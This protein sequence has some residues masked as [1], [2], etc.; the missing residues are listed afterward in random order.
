MFSRSVTRPDPAPCVDEAADARPLGTV[1]CACRFDA[2][3]GA[4]AHLIC[5][6]PPDLTDDDE[7]AALSYRVEQAGAE[8]LNNIVE[9]AYKGSPDG[10]IQAAIWLAQG[11]FFLVTRDRG[12]PFAPVPP[13]TSARDESPVDLEL[14]PD[15]GFGWPIIR[16]SADDIAYDRIDGW[17]VLILEFRA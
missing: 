9:H 2:I 14:L 16:G 15:R 11:S 10:E 5:H 17:N 6:L 13:I 4:L 3:A 12:R 7:P 8:V 1:C